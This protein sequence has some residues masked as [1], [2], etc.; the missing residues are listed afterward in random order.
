MR[1]S[2]PHIQQLRLTFTLALSLSVGFPV[3]AQTFPPQPVNL[4]NPLANS[5]ANSTVNLN[6]IEQPL[7]FNLPDMTDRGR[8]GER[9]GGGSR[10]PCSIDPK[11]LYA[12]VPKDGRGLT[13]SGSPSFWFRI[14]Y[15]STDYHSL[16][17]QLTRFWNSGKREALVY[18]KTLSAAEV[19]TG[20]VSIAVP[21]TISLLETEPT[22][23][24][25]SLAAYCQNSEPNSELVET[26]VVYGSI[27]RIQPTPELTQALETAATDRDRARIYA[28]QGLWYDSLTV[29]G[30]LN[31]SSL[32]QPEL[33]ADWQALLKSVGLG[34]IAT[35][36]LADCCNVARN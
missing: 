15:S 21:E 18:E 30:Y 34:Q 32:D 16:K 4:A 12:L 29:L 17:F 26:A 27:V 1:W 22:Y 31:R 3:Q 24:E 23:Y 35:E 5:L 11:E 25:W 6:S 14:P 28:E 33:S 19:P 8:P 20:I 7:Q 13:V 9:S 10:G 36:P 2:K